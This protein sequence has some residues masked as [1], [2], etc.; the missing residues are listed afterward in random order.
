MLVSFSMSRIG[1]STAHADIFIGHRLA[2]YRTVEEY[3]GYI[4]SV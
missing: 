3:S 1:G 2:V 4:N